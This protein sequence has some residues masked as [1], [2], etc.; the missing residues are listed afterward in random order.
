MRADAQ[1]G[2]E[3]YQRHCHGR[4]VVGYGAANRIQ[5][6]AQRFVGKTARRAGEYIM[7]LPE[8]RRA[9]VQFAKRIGIRAGSGE[10]Q[11]QIQEHRTSKKCQSE[12][13]RSRDLR[14]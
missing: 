3:Q 6:S 9:G 7:M 10:Y 2:I 1:E 14:A 12:P 13:A 8:Q 5:N 11:R 4:K